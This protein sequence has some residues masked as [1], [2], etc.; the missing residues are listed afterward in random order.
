[1]SIVTPSFNQSQYL[2]ETI[3]SVLLQGYPDLE[4][5]VIDGGSSDGSLEIIKKYEPWLAY[6]VSQ[7][8]RGQSHAL[9]KGFGRATGEIY[10]WLNSDDTYQPNGLNIAA[11]HLVQRPA[12]G[13]VYGHANVI[14]PQGLLITTWL[15]SKFHLKEQLFQYQYIPQQS[16]FF[17]RTAFEQVGAID[18]TF[19]YTMDYDLWLRLGRAFQVEHIS[20]ILSNYR[21]HHTSKTVSNRYANRP[22]ILRSLRRFFA[23]PT[24]PADLRDLERAAY[25]IVYLHQG[26]GAFQENKLEQGKVYLEKALSIAPKLTKLCRERILRLLVAYAP[27]IPEQAATYFQTIRPHLPPSAN[28][29]QQL[30]ALAQNRVF[31]IAAAR[32]LDIRQRRQVICS[33]GFALR[34]D[35]AWC[36]DKQVLTS[37]IS[38]LGGPQVIRVLALVKHRLFL[39]TGPLIVRETK[40]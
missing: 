7:P 36:A 19:Y 15:A 25:A 9:N 26:L 28:D 3:R 6:W 2:E 30:L 16:A 4:Y 17:R 39:P 31:I 20:H 22:E 21:E 34:R 5:I 37:V 24:L 27:S 23:D 38:L 10:A 12:A 32:S 33:I 11:R 29:L 14:D 35:V 40:S 1:V 8:D 18:E 13:M